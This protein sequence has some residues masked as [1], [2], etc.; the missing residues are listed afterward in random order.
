MKQTVGL[1]GVWVGI[2]LNKLESVFVGSKEAANSYA[3]ACHKMLIKH[4]RQKEYSV[5]ALPYRPDKLPRCS[6]ISV[7]LYELKEFYG[8]CATDIELESFW[9]NRNGTWVEQV[10]ELD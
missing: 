10:K 8:G 1:Y 7:E 9:V 4:G 3:D 2:A 5:F 6:N